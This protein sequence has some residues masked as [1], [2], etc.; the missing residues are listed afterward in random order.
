M[1]DYVLRLNLNCFSQILGDQT[2]RSLSE[3]VDRLQ[4]VLGRDV[5]AA[6]HSVAADSRLSTDGFRF[7]L[8]PKVRCLRL[9]DSSQIRE[10]CQF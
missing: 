1:F 7:V 9:T 3:E 4:R 8:V 5:A 6:P 2:L 10:D